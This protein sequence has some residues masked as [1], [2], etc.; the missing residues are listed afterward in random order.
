MV[1]RVQPLCGT[2]ASQC[3][4]QALGLP[5]GGR[6]CWQGA[7]AFA[8]CAPCPPHH[9]PQ[10]AGQERTMN[11]P[12]EA[13]S[14]SRAGSRGFLHHHRVLSHQRRP[15]H[16]SDRQGDGAAGKPRLRENSAARTRGLRRCGAAELQPGTSLRAQDRG[17]SR[18]GSVP[19]GPQ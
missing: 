16:L 5:G 8:R 7:G 11:G 15:S 2:D 12:Q 14:P 10:A 1:Q 4:P 18:L 9:T 19:T 17:R 3:C 6:R 13:A